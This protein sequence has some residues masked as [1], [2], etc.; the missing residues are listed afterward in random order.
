MGH[1]RS[2]LAVV[3][4]MSSVA[5]IRTHFLVAVE[6]CLPGNTTLVDKLLLFQI[7][8]FKNQWTVNMSSFVGSDWY[9]NKILTKQTQW[10]S[11]IYQ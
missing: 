11:V 7:G 6:T 9:F 3:S 10:L 8:S 4:D 2:F 5:N 1:W